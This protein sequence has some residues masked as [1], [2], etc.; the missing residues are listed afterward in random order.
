MTKN[1]VTIGS[2]WGQSLIR[3]KKRTQKK[4]LHDQCFIQWETESTLFGHKNPKR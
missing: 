1:T 2:D 3:M 4:K